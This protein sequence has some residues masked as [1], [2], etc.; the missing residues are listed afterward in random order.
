M[1]GVVAL[2]RDGTAQQCV[3]KYGCPQGEFGGRPPASRGG[4]YVF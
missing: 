1:P 2:G 3:V 4:A